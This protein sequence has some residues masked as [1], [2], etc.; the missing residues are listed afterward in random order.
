MLTTWPS[1]R[2]RVRRGEHLLGRDI[3]IAGDAVLGGRRAA[4]PFMFVGEA[5]RQVGARPGIMQ[6]GE[7]MAVQPLGAAAQRRIM[8]RPGRDRIDGIDARGREN[9]RAELGH[10]HIRLVMREDLLRPGDARISDDVPIDVEARD[11]FQRR[12]VGDRIGAIGA[13]DLGRI[14]ARE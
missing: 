3:G 5:D 11:L 10:R 7:A 8:R 6:G 2:M 14:L 12:L 9:R 13:R 4:L 1:T